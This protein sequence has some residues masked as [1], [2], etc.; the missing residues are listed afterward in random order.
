[1][2]FAYR[3]GCTWPRGG[4]CMFFFC[5]SV[6]WAVQEGCAREALFP[7]WTQPSAKPNPQSRTADSGMDLGLLHFEGMDPFLIAQV[8]LTSCV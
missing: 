5:T 1:M 7:T 3:L 2:I 8:P 4:F 6:V